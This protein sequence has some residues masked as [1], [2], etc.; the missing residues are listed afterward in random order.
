MNIKPYQNNAKKHPEK[1]IQQIADRIK[2]FGMNQPIVVDKNGTIIVGHGRYL[3]LQKLGWEIKPEW[4]IKKED[5]TDEEVK[6]YRLADNKLNESEWDLKLAVEELKELSD[7]MIE[8]TGFDRD[9]LIE[10]DE[11]EDDVPENVPA[12][13]K[14]MEL[15]PKYIDTIVQRYVDYTGNENI[16]LNG[17][18]IKWQKSQ[19][20]KE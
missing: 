17:K 3:A 10:A 14:L 5:L 6:A 11:R 20:K 12:R 16:K 18:E 2:R 8:L 9:L 19:P 4:I 15:D 7:E 1:Q 13:S